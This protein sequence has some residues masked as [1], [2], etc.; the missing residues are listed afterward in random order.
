[1]AV[2]WLK[3]KYKA[4]KRAGNY[5]SKHNDGS[6]RRAPKRAISE[7]E[8]ARQRATQPLV[9]LHVL[10]NGKKRFVKEMRSEES[11]DG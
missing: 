4:S 6:K 10:P 1:M 8:K 9:T 2:T 7:K 11:I 5:K 3:A